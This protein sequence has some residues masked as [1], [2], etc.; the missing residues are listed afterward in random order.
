MDADE[1][2]HIEN[3]V[4]YSFRHAELLRKALTHSSYA[5]E[6]D[7]EVPNNERLEFLGDAVLE[8]SV[9]EYL[10]SAFRGSRE[11]DL[12]RMRAKLVSKPALAALARDIGIDQYLLLGKGEEIQGGRTRNSLLSDALEALLGAI[13]LDGGYTEAKAWVLNLYADKWPTASDFGRSRD[14]KSRLQ[15][16]TQKTYRERP[17]YVLTASHGPEHDK[18]FEVRLTLPDGR[19]VDAGGQS[20]KKAEQR[21]AEIALGM[22]EKEAEA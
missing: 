15:E 18:V 9:S 21:A 12:T 5:N 7:G 11:G 10:F 22:L 19:T 1:R 4:G 3:V 14:F 17:V 6:V 16:V 20:M 13:F 2:R 8:L